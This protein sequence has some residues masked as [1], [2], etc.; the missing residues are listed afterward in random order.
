MAE[1][2]QKRKLSV[3]MIVRDAADYLGETLKSIESIADEIVVLDT[4]SQDSTLELARQHGAKVFEQDWDDSFS[5]ARNAALQQTTG[6]CVFWI[7]AGEVMSKEDAKG[8]RAFVDSEMDMMT[9]Y[10][11]LVKIPQEEKGIGS[12]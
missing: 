1:E 3:A 10:V 5:S 12:E 4:G 7:D 11:L 6:D 9:A 2:M 8:L